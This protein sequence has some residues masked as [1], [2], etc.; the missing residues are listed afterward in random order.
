MSA[1]TTP[2]GT[3]RR[4]CL[5]AVPVVLAPA[6]PAC[7]GESAGSA[8][9]AVT[10]AIDNPWLPLRPGTRL[11]YEGTTARGTTTGLVEVTGERRGVLGV[12]VTVV[13]GTVLLGGEVIEETSGWYAQDR[14]GNVWCFGEDG[15]RSRPGRSWRAGRDGA[16]PGLAMRA[17]PR[18]GDAYAQRNAPG[19]AEDRAVV[20]SV[21]ESVQVPFGA[22]DHVLRIRETTPGAPGTEHHACY[23]RGIGLLRRHRTRGG[24]D[25]LALSRVEAP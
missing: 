3:R 6:L 9:R 7:G 4:S 13:R 15:G 21:A 8:P 16:E 25:D 23:A 10:G 12:T 17:D 24:H 22:F 18:P 14:E 11:H 20:L 1:V 5:L 19:V 2:R